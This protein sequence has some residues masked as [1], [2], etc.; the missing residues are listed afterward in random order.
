MNNYGAVRVVF[1]VVCITLTAALSNATADAQSDEQVRQKA[2]ALS[3][4][5]RTVTPDML[6]DPANAEAIRR[7][8]IEAKQPHRN[9][10]RMPLLRMRDPEVIA[11]CIA[12]FHS[13]QFATRQQAAQQL[14]AS[15][16]PVVI[17]LVADD[18]FLNESTATVFVTPEF[19]KR[20]LS[21][22]AG[23]I[24]QAI[25]A[26]SPEFNHATKEWAA[27]L[28]HRPSNERNAVR[29][30]M[31]QWWLQSKSSIASQK[32]REVKPPSD[33]VGGNHR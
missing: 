25:I 2:E 17:S 23:D 32:Y 21:V 28:S 16:N 13:E 12:E 5:W 27:S 30:E 14:K 11:Q 24:I 18:L 26:D 19:R 22:Y 31:R 10:A 20:P 9:Y 8:R 6:R 15:A 3:H 33:A 4:N 7:L 1:L 29:D